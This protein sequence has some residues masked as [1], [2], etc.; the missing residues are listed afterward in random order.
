MP[1]YYS[2]YV[3]WRQILAALFP[4][5][6]DPTVDEDTLLCYSTPACRLGCPAGS[7]SHSTGKLVSVQTIGRF[8]W[9]GAAIVFLGVSCLP[10]GREAQPAVIAAGAQPTPTMA[11]AEVGA[12]APVFEL[13]DLEG[14][15][16]KL[17]DLRGQVVLLSFWA[18]WCGHCR[19]E[20]P[21]LEAFYKRHQNE[22][23]VVLAINIQENKDRVAEL[24]NDMG[25]TFPVLLDRRG[26]VT[27]SYRVR[28]LPTNFLIDREGTILEKHI[29]PV[30]E[31]MLD[32]YLAQAATR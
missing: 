5:M 32:G 16:I 30:T 15:P 24:V 1:C 12:L 22:G 10:A 23:F 13:I 26:E 14:D 4:H 28:S 3:S 29:G 9:I 2:M 31:S 20:L 19:S 8:L 7:Q 17:S 6:C 18:T 21:V 11:T 25:L 27:A